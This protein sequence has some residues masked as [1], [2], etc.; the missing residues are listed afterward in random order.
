MKHF[1]LGPKGGHVLA[2]RGKHVYNTFKNSD[3]K[4]IITL[5]M[6]NAKGEIAPPL[7]LYKYKIMNQNVVQNAPDVSMNIL[8]TYSCHISNKKELH[9]QSYCF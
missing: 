3:K 9:F 7:P 2:L 5:L 6:A 4:N 8:G 1:F